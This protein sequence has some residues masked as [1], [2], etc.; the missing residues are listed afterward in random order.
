MAVPRP[1]RAWTVWWKQNWRRFTDDPAYSR[2][3]LPPLP[4][5]PR[6]AAMTAAQP[7]PTGNRVLVLHGPINAIVGPPPPEPQP[8]EYYRT[9]MD[10]DTGQERQ[11]A[12]NLPDPAK[13]KDSGRRRL[14]G[15][16]R[17]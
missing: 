12:G 13:V 5:A 10:L 7:F 2:I 16:G 8:D 17:F 1:R 4:A 14:R 15:T 6:V 9:F 11:V 3:S